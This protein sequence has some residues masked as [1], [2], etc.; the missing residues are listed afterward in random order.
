M[1]KQALLFDLTIPEVCVNQYDSMH[2]SAN[3]SKDKWKKTGVWAFFIGGNTEKGIPIRFVVEIRW[4][5]PYLWIDKVSMNGLHDASG[6]LK[7]TV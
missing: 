2:I 3:A 4:Q 7:K 6:D 5:F 1:T